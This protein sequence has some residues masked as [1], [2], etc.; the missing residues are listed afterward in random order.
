MAKIDNVILTTGVDNDK[1]SVELEIRVNSNGTISLKSNGT[2]GNH[3]TQ[4]YTLNKQQI[5][6]LIK[7]LETLK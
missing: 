1:T 3:T 7:I 2:S 5:E 4:I 6:D